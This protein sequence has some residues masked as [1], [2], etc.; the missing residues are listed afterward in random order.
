VP[1]AVPEQVETVVWQIRLP[2]VLAGVAIGAALA[3]SGASFQTIF[4]NPLVA[5]DILGVSAGAGF[6]AALG[7]LLGL[8]I[9]VIQLL[10]FFFG[11][12]AVIVVHRVATAVRRHDPTLVL[13]LSGV[14]VGALLGACTSLVKYLADSNNTLPSIVFW[15]MGSLSSISSADLGHALPPILVGLVP[16]WLLRFRIS[17]LG[18]V[19]RKERPGD[20]LSHGQAEDGPAPETGGDRFFADG[21][22]DSLGQQIRSPLSG[23]VG[24]RGRGS[25]QALGRQLIVGSLSNDRPTINLL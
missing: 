13:V 5:P 18:Q 22:R 4:R 21:F 2:R 1:A 14:V 6:G 7:L 3:V 9:T 10:S 16:L 24:E 19:S 20:A 11:L 25:A 17:V 12:V 8:P 15:M 23:A